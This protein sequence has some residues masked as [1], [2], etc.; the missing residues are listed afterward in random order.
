MLHKL[1]QAWL[2]WKENRELE[3]MDPCY[4]NTYVE[5]QVK[6]C[7]QVGLLCVQSVVDDRPTMPCVFLMLSSEESVLPQPKKPGFFL[8]RSPQRT[9][10]G[11]CITMTMSEVEAR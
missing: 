1:L 2:L 11:G 7:V 4:N 9:E 5:S 6:R 10:S 8:H 3:L